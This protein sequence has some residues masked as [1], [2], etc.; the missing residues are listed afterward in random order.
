LHKL[1]AGQRIYV[2]IN[3][4]DKILGWS[5]AQNQRDRLGRTARNLIASNAIY[6][7]FTGGENVGNTHQLWGEVDHPSVIDFFSTCFKG[8][9]AEESSGFSYDSRMN[10]YRIQRDTNS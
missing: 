9:R 10:A 5:E 3:E 7:D 2:T 4:K 6:V 8:E 1:V